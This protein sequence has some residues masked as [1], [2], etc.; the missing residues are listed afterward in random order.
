MRREQ[1][2]A[3]ATKF[4]TTSGYLLFHRCPVPLVVL[5]MTLAGLGLSAYAFFWLAPGVILRAYPAESLAALNALIRGQAA[6]AVAE[7]LEEWHNLAVALLIIEATLGLVVAL[8]TW[9]VTQRF[10]DAR[11]GPAPA[12]SRLGMSTSRIATVSALVLTFV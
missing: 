4:K 3:R 2:G 12:V 5:A 11:F 9:C 6:H 7:Y 8:L 10:I 1:P